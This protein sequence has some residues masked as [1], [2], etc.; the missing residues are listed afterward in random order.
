[1]VNVIPRLSVAFLPKVFNTRYR[2]ARMTNR[3]DRFGRVIRKMLFDGDDMI[4]VPQS[5]VAKR[6]DLDIEIE[7]AGQRNVVPS[8][9]VKGVIDNSRDIFLM[10][11]C[12]CRKS[13]HCKD[14]PADV[15]CIFIGKGTHRIPLEYGRFL[16]K[17]EANVFIDE[18][19]KMGL[20]HIIGRNKL[21]S[22]WLH[23]GDHHDLLTIC[24]CCPCCCLWNMVRDI[25]KD[26]SAVYTRMDGA[27]ISMDAD[28]CIGCG[29]CR[30]ICFAKAVTIEGSKAVID[31]D[32]CRVCG[33]CA[34]VCPKDAIEVTYD[35][36]CVESEVQR[37]LKLVNM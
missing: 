11:F 34:N 22:I 26:I 24:N 21:D 28:R 37:I 4:V 3:Y 6:I 31:Q 10:N 13:N 18:C 19:D 35:P 23:T 33:R 17:E 15:G 12:L 29:Q 1:M 2:L 7:D 8:D 14:Y 32:K 9:V 30:D 5:G 25:N 27:S 16:T 20:V 36:S